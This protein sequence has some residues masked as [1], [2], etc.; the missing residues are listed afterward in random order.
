[1]ARDLELAIDVENVV[2][3]YGPTRALDGV[4]LQVEHGESRALAGRNGAGKSTL[5]GVLTGM[6]TPDSGRVTLSRPA[7]PAGTA[8][9]ADHNAPTIACVY[10]KSTLVPNLSAAENIALGMYPQR[11]GGLVD[12]RAIDDQAL[13]LLGE[14]GAERVASRLVG[15]LAPVERKIVEICRASARGASAL[16]LDEPTAGLDEGAAEHLFDNLEQARKRGVTLI[17]VSHHLDELYKVCDSI[18]V[19]RD[20]KDIHTGSIHSLA[21]NDIVHLMVGDTPQTEPEEFMPRRRRVDVDSA[22]EVLAA[23]DVVLDGWPGPTGLVVHGGECLGLTGL[24]GAGHVAMARAMAG[25]VEPASG[26]VL[27]SGRAL[28]VGDIRRAIDAGVGFVPEDRHESGFV[29]AMS[30][31]ENATMTILK[32]LSG[33]VGLVRS[34]QRRQRYMGLADEWSIKAS[35]PGQAISELSGGNQQKVVLARALASDPRAIVLINPTAGVDVAAKESIYHTI[36]LL[37]EQGRAVVICSSDDADLAIC[38]RVAV[39]FKG[40]LHTEL[41]APWSERDLVT[42]VQGGD[43]KDTPAD[44][45]VDPH[46]R[47]TH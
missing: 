31:E 41:T 17:Y 15:D 21:V 43:P 10:Q 16:L 14:W 5:I 40:R 33:R 25:F 24:D 29:P 23:H 3:M 6:V 9:Q 13:R 12:W 34:G 28:P 20:G 42:A 19:I 7:A 18:T 8:I 11:R 44:T 35:G 47:P 1:M 45:E 39:M 46:P 27:L 38:D 2:K 36:G 22:D 26:Q 30:V 4:G 32:S 37:L